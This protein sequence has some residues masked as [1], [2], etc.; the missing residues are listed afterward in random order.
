MSTYLTAEG[1]QIR[2]YDGV[3]NEL[4]SLLRT[5]FG[6]S[7]NL[8]N[9]SPLG[10]I[11]SVIALQIYTEYLDLADIFN[12]LFIGTAS[13]LML[14]NLVGNFGITRLQPKRST[15]TVRFCVG[16]S[17]TGGIYNN[18]GV[19]VLKGKKVKTQNGKVFETTS[20]ALIEKRMQV[21]TITG[22]ASG[23]FEIENTSIYL[24]NADAGA[25][26]NAIA[27]ATY[28]NWIVEQNGLE[29]TFLN[30]YDSS[31]PD[32]TPLDV[33]VQSSGM[34]FTR[35]ITGYYTDITVQSIDLGDFNVDAKAINTLVDSITGVFK[36]YNPEET[37]NGRDL[38][39]DANLRARFN[40]S[41]FRT[42]TCSLQAIKNEVLN[43]DGVENCIVVENATNSIVDSIQPHSFEVI[44]EGS[45]SETLYQNIAEKIFAYKPAGI[46][47]SGN[48]TKTVNFSDTLYSVKL[49]RAI[50]I[51]VSV[52]MTIDETTV[53][54]IHGTDYET[55]IKTV[56]VDYINNLGIGQK[57]VSSIILGKAYA[58]YPE[59]INDISNVVLS[60]TIDG[61]LVEGS[62]I[63]FT[64]RQFSQTTI[65]D[66]TLAFT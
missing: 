7:I 4:K 18:Y 37:V 64:K 13:G 6:A 8:E 63:T 57:L 54:I 46:T 40:N 23:S 21:I 20:R 47:S 17:L 55:Q 65:E 33:D 56:I 19:E 9:N 26:A 25:T 5:N 53:D 51:T 34:T 10:M 59:A 32:T 41:V 39:S 1:L 31:Y 16:Y 2:T 30:K 11:I 38:E 22:G 14:N 27:A 29:L 24:S 48:I 58:V 28:T 36:V 43:L 60:A 15:G 66:I 52:S 61:V 44:F 12:N 50:G 35:R 62:S 3:L 45:E 42:A 49:T